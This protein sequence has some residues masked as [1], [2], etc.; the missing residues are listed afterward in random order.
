VAFTAFLFTGFINLQPGQNEF[1]I[2]AFD[3]FVLDVDGRTLG[4]FENSNPNGQ[5]RYFFDA[6]EGG[7]KRFELLYFDNSGDISGLTA[8]LNGRVINAS[9]TQT[10][11]DPVA[12]VPLPSSATL[13]AAALLALARLRRRRAIPI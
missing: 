4:S 5:N 12:P 6:M 8:V 10:D 9:I 13:F 11:L 2:Q 7:L 1:F 3:G